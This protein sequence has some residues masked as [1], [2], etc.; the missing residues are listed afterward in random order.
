MYDGIDRVM[1]LMTG[2]KFS[3]N[4]KY[5]EH[6][7]I[8]DISFS[9][10]DFIWCMLGFGC[11]VRVLG[12]FFILAF[13]LLTGLHVYSHLAV[14]LH[15]IKRRLGTTFGLIW[16]AIGVSLLYNIIFNHYCATIIKPGGPA[17]LKVIILL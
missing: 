10:T 8:F 16:V 7:Y 15:V 5:L 17:H 6:S 11:S 9:H 4:S 14:V 2:P 13:Y 1:D 3:G 12:P